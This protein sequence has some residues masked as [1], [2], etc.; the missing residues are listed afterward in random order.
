L[1]NATVTT[2]ANVPAITSIGNARLPAVM[3]LSE[4]F[5]Y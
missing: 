4:R 5:L 3:Q 1:I 2:A